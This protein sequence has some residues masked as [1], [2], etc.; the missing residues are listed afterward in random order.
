M[1]FHNKKIDMALY[2]TFIFAFVAITVLKIKNSKD[3]T[4]QGIAKV[5]H[6]ESILEDPSERLY[7]DP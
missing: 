7:E 3:Q 2:Y 4:A 6:C 5:R 1:L